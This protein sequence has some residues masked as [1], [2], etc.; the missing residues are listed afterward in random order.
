MAIAY[1]TTWTTYGSWPPGDAR[2]WWA[3]G[4]GPQPGDSIRQLEAQLRMTED[5]NYL[6]PEQR[7]LVETTI[8]KHCDIR[9]WLLHAV[10]CRSNHV[11]VVV[12]APGQPLDQPR[13][14]FKAWCTR[15]LKKQ[16]DSTRVNWWTSRGW[17]VYV[18]DEPHLEMAIRYVID[19]QDGR[20][21]H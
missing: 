2:G 10:N 13:K 11:H 6:T 8:R 1:F 14:Q 18:D 15:L 20:H 12:S 4:R 7:Q 16:G 5:A 9:A 21:G 17:D 3:H 19:G